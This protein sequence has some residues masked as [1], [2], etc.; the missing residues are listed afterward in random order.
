LTPTLTL[1]PTGTL[2]PSLTSTGSCDNGNVTFKVTNNG[3]SPIPA[4]VTYTI[5][6]SSGKTLQSGALQTLAVGASTTFTVSNVTGTLTLTIKG[7][8]VNAIFTEQCTTN[9]TVVPPTATP[10]LPTATVKPPSHLPW[11]AINPGPAV[12]ENWLV[13]HTDQVSLH[14]TDKGTGQEIF[15]LGDL[16]NEKGTPVDLS[17]TPNLKLPDGT[18]VQNAGPSLSPDRRYI[19]FASNRDGAWDLYVASTSGLGAVKRMTYGANIDV[20][21]AWSP[22]G[23]YIAYESAQGGNWNLYLFDVRQPNAEPVQITDTPATDSQPYWSSDSKQIVFESNRS[24]TVQLYVYDLATKQTTRMTNDAN[25]N[26]N[27]TYSPDGKHIAYRS[28]TAADPNNDVLIIADAD[29]KNAK[30]ISV[31]KGTTLNHSWNSNSDLIAYQ[32]NM[33]GQNDVYV[34]QLSTGKTRLVTDASDK[35]AHYAPTWYCNSTTLIF[36]SDVTGNANIFSTDGSVDLPPIKV[37]TQAS[38]LTNITKFQAHYAENFPPQEEEGS[39]L[40]LEPAPSKQ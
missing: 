18:P 13:Y 33:M 27:P 21:P 39:R 4:G 24:G 40:I 1:T 28:Y 10:P 8:T 36:T 5:A 32:S 2:P 37:A 12:C 6:D 19:S 25:N 17:Q 22:D 3:G 23:T 31:G 35:V 14:T 34:Y 20:A 16:P 9:V 15:R 7:Q 30:T 29:G 38:N 11:A 26:F